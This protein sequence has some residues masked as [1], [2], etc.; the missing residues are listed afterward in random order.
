[1][2][3]CMPCNLG[4]RVRKTG[5]LSVIGNTIKDRIAGNKSRANARLGLVTPPAG[6]SK[7]IWIRAGASRDSVLLA[8]GLMAAIRHKRLDVRL[9]LSYEEEYQDIIVDQLSGLEK[10]GFGYACENSGFTEMR[11][12]QRLEP[13]AI[14][15]A[16][17]A[18]GEG[19]IQALQKIPVK[20][21]VNFQSSNTDSLEMELS[22]P[23]FQ[24]ASSDEP[25][26]EAM[27]LLMQAQV[28]AQLGALLKGD[29]QKSL[30][31][32][33]VADN[34]ELASFL[35]EW[36]TSALKENAVLCLHQADGA[37]TLQRLVTQSGLKPK[38][39]SQWDREMA[40]TSDT[41]AVLEL[42]QVSIMIT[43]H[44]RRVIH[45]IRQL[46]DHAFPEAVDPIRVVLE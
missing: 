37:E 34:S 13:F 30:F 44:G 25:S 7:L 2:L 16:G 36:K 22:Y 18:P 26:F 1:M 35:Q 9:V 39:L 33:N 27:S 23:D 6:K 41:V 5:I 46:Q 42:H 45:I 29:S 43:T 32:L 8:A 28:D 20:H 40:V 14:I 21:L 4:K 10:I 12:L 19:I 17:V 31:L 24:H 15:F 38:M 11:M 3:H